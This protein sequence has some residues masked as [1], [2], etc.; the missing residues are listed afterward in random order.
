MPS[1][2]SQEH[3]CCDRQKGQ[4]GRLGHDRVDCT[5]AAGDGAVVREGL[6]GGEEDVRV[7]ALQAGRARVADAV[8][9]GGEAV[10]GDLASR[11]VLFDNV[12]NCIAWLDEEGTVTM[13]H[14]Q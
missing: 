5:D 1:S 8:C 4:R 14:T 2:S 12:Y 10:C 13:T 6:A 7:L 11:A 3:C 9:A